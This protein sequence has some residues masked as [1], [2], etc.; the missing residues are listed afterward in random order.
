MALY[1]LAIMT[2][3]VLTTKVRSI[4]QE[5]ARDYNSKR[6]LRIPPHITLV[7]P[8]KGEDKFED[9]LNTT[10]SAFSQKQDPFDIDL[11][12]FGSFRKKVVFIDVVDN[13][14]LKSLYSNLIAYLRENSPLDPPVYHEHFTPHVT[15]ANRDLSYKAF[16]KCWPVFSK[17]KFS[18]CFTVRSLCLLKHN[19]QVWEVLHEYNFIEMS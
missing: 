4:Q 6:Q 1:F 17:R 13:E 10:L 18:E 12:N 9:E 3:P 11:K 19:G 16:E 7:P 15:V 5:F 14:K 8:F 2:P